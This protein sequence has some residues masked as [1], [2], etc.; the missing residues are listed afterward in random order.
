MPGNAWI[1]VTGRDGILSLV[2]LWHLKNSQR[3]VWAQKRRPRTVSG[4]GTLLPQV[5]LSW[6]PGMEQDADLV[7]RMAPG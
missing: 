4:A 3:K 6:K 7:T 5:M 1:C 2:F